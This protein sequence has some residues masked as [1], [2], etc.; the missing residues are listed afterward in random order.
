MQLEPKD[1][2]EKLEFDKENLFHV[3]EDEEIEIDYRHI[4]RLINIANNF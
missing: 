3:L 2:Y 4:E 1:L